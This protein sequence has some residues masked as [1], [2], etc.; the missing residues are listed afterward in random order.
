MKR[1]VSSRPEANRLFGYSVAL[2]D[3]T[4]VV[5]EPGWIFQPEDQIGAVEAD[6]PLADDDN[7]NGNGGNG[8]MITREDLDGAEA[9]IHDQVSVEFD[10][11]R[12]K[13]DDGEPPPKQWPNFTGDR[14]LHEVPFPSGFEM[15]PWRGGIIAHQ[16]SPGAQPVLVL[17][18]PTGGLLAYNWKGDVLW[19]RRNARPRLRDGASGGAN[20][21]GTNHAGLFATGDRL[22][23]VNERGELVLRS[24]DNGALLD[25]IDFSGAA[26][27][28]P[29]VAVLM[30]VDG[31]AHAVLQFDKTNLWAVN[32]DTGG[33]EWQADDYVGFDHS[34][35]FCADLD[36]DGVD[37]VLGAISL[38]GSDGSRLHGRGIYPDGT[39]L[40]SI[41]SV[42]F[43]D[44]DSDGVVEMIFAEQGGRNATVCVRPT[45]PVVVWTNTDR[46]AEPIGDCAREIDPDKVTCG[47]FD[48][49][50]PGLEVQARSAC[51]R[52]PWIIGADG[53][54]IK[55][56]RVD[57]VYE[58]TDW[59]LGQKSD[60]E[61]GIDVVSALNW[62][63]NDHENRILL[64]KERHIEGDVGVYNV[65]TD[66]VKRGFIL[67]REAIVPFPVDLA[68]DRR[69]EIVVVERN[70]LAI[71]WHLPKIEKPHTSRGWTSQVYARQRQNFGYY[72][73]A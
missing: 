57:D 67:Q 9:R 34:P 62:H 20:L 31:L 14:P 21:P 23:F 66:P 25:T 53:R 64:V 61:G 19:W 70:R 36:G 27:G 42:T 41:D 30:T 13:L 26:P 22:G 7:G 71:Q 8:G 45:E 32:L 15:H 1:H 39:A 40:G 60:S 10:R 58:G 52:V 29:Q 28:P 43:G 3:G 55:H 24:I 37:E 44:V 6:P 63:G 4:L 11:L 50:L 51:G 68:G 59:N 48:P 69:E 46:P 12:A 16:I 73:T 72:S 38:R 5:G 54:T 17:S 33:V 47:N 65:A 18:S 56:F 2:G 49:A 35:V